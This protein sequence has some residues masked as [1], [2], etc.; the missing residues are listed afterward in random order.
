M[1]NG[2]NLLADLAVAVNMFDGGS[3][4]QCGGCPR[5]L[6]GA[7]CLPATSRFAAEAGSCMGSRQIY[8]CLINWTILITSYEVS[9]RLS[10]RGLQLRRYIWISSKI[11]LDAALCTSN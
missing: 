7:R 10:L 5:V 3:D 4:S 6:A 9:I 2:Q 1:A 11:E 8:S